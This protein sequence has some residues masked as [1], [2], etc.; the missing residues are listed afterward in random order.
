MSLKIRKG[1][2]VIYVIRVAPSQGTGEYMV[3][4]DAFA[5]VD[6]EGMHWYGKL[7]QL[8]SDPAVGVDELMVAKQ[9]IKPLPLAEVEIWKPP[10]RGGGGGRGRGGRRGGRGRGRAGGAA[11]ADEVALALEDDGPSD[12]DDG[13][14]GSGS[15]RG[16]DSS[17][18]LDGGSDDS[19]LLSD[20]DADSVAT[21]LSWLIGSDIE[22]CIGYALANPIGCK[23]IL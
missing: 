7:Y 6:L 14:D 4:Y 16:D 10:K 23:W 8:C 3:E 1:V 22:V 11:V 18:P 5:T 19:P 9:H 20:E 12:G 21:D 15:G 17:M 13:G 2:E